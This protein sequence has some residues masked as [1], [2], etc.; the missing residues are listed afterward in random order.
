MNFPP[1]GRDAIEI[2]RAVNEKDN[3]VSLMD[4]R[5]NVTLSAEGGM[6]R[7]FHQTVILSTGGMQ[8]LPHQPSTKM[9]QYL[10]RINATAF[11]PFMES[12]FIDAD[13]PF[14]TEY[15][16]GSFEPILCQI[17]ITSNKNASPD[18]KCSI[19][20]ISSETIDIEQPSFASRQYVVAFQ[21]NAAVE[22]WSSDFSDLL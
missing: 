15:N 7:A 19:E 10:I 1:G 21:I 22:F 18:S 4:G 11:L 9:E 14:I 6:H 13:D 16:S 5:V 2:S 3:I 20:F 8:P 17:S 12:V